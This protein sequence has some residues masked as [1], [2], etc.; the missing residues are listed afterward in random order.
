MRSCE[1][2]YERSPRP[3]GPNRPNKALAVLSW[4]NKRSP[5]SQSL[6]LSSISDDT[7]VTKIDQQCIG[8]QSSPLP[9][10]TVRNSLQEY[11]FVSIS[12]GPA[13][14]VALRNAESECQGNDHSLGDR[15]KVKSSQ[16]ED[17]LV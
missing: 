7:V 5:S 4:K 12:S 8:N 11:A 6:A 10:A 3:L 16:R 2:R 14:R 17:A 13:I 15:E 1:A 9:W